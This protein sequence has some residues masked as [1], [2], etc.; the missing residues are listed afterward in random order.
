MPY[1]FKEINKKYS[2]RICLF[3][4]VILAV[5]LLIFHSS[6][7]YGQDKIRQEPSDY[8]IVFFLVESLRADRLSCYGYPL[9]TT[10]YIDELVKKG[11]LFEHAF[12][13]S[14]ST[15][16]SDMSILTSLYPNAHNVRHLPR[17]KLANYITTLPQI[18]NIYGYHTVLISPAG[19]S[20]FCLEADFQRGFKEK[21]IL[22]NKIW[23]EEI[24]RENRNKDKI[25]NQ[26]YLGLGWLDKIKEKKFFILFYLDNL[27]KPYLP[28]RETKKN[29]VTD[30]LL[31][32]QDITI[33]MFLRSALTEIKDGSCLDFEDISTKQVYKVRRLLDKYLKFDFLTDEEILKITKELSSIIGEP[34]FSR[35]MGDLYLNNF[36]LL[37]NKEVQRLKA[38]YDACVFDIDAY[39]HYL[40]DKL[41]E[42]G[43]KDKTIIVISSNHGEAFGE[44]G[45]F[46][47]E[48]L[49]EEEI[50][51]PLIFRIPNI[52]NGKRIENMVE[53]I[54][55]M[56]TILDVAGITVPVQA[57][58]RSL[59]PLIRGSPQ[60]FPERF[61]YGERDSRSY[62]RS[63]EWKLIKNYEQGIRLNYEAYNIKNDPLERLNIAMG[64][65][66]K[67]SQFRELFMF[68]EEKLFSYYHPKNFYKNLPIINEE[69]RRRII[70]EGY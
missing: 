59:L 53:S 14:S 49:Y 46:F 24:S 32:N 7:T 63:K 66:V 61:V 34:L 35:L 28:S 23:R 38:Q 15:I 45:G 17:D 42:F 19:E 67:V 31:R 65:H 58:G 43:L 51:I 11:I 57:Q 60:D 20:G 69:T 27:Q 64:G 36:N 50:R 22:A 26:E 4:A 25:G 56:P 41:G 62:V 37:D 8:N 33:T 30:S 47:H 16:Q 13:Q 18:L 9:K 1:Q 2:H 44:H 40:S 54:D 70:H 6:V 12:S 3:F 39:I 29:F 68:W 10:P 5:I 52:K 48:R 55:I 21:Y